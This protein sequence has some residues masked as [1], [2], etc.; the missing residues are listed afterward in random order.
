MNIAGPRISTTGKK[1]SKH[2]WASA[3]AKHNAETLASEWT[4]IKA[5]HGVDDLARKSTRALTSRNYVPPA[6]THRCA[7]EP[8]LP[9][10]AT[11]WSQCSKPEVKIYT[12]DK[13][14]GI[15]TMHKSNAVPVFSKEAAID[16]AKMRR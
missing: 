8:R 1:K 10:L 3:E 13:I 5:R 11:T 9:S 14:T 12:G 2:K 4:A 15:S 6:P 7:D 16:I